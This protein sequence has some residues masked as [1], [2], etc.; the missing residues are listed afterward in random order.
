MDSNLGGC[1]A[2]TPKLLIAHNKKNE[3]AVAIFI[4]LFQLKRLF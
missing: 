4:L 2:T 1:L 3:I